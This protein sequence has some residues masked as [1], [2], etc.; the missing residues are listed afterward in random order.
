MV[1]YI[2]KKFDDATKYTTI[3]FFLNMAIDHNQTGKRLEEQTTC[4]YT[5][6]SGYVY[7]CSGIPRCDRARG[8]R[9][10]MITYST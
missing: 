7:C 6:F 9:N 4:F 1:Y 8:Q 10:H 5:V 2:Y 3:K